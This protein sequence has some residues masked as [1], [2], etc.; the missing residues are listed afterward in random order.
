MVFKGVV[1]GDV[2][3]LGAETGIRTKLSARLYGWHLARMPGL[4]SGRLEVGEE[5][6]IVGHDRGPDVG[7]E[8][9]EPRQVQ[10][11]KP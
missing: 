2:G 6:E 7:L 4:A 1:G 5:S 11:A 9:V 8:V 10:R 3:W